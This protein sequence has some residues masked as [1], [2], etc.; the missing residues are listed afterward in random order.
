MIKSYNPERVIAVIGTVPILEW[1][2]LNVQ[3]GGGTD[4]LKGK[5][6]ELCRGKQWGSGMAQV[7][8]IIP[9]GSVTNALLSTLMMVDLPIPIHL[10]DTNDVL[11]GT[12]VFIYPASFVKVPDDSYSRVSNDITWILQGNLVQSTQGTYI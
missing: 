2:E 1:T 9:K 6:K 4:L 10:V 11:G 12:L 3:I 5:D 7:E 8:L